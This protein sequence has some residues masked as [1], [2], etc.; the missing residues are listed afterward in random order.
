MGAR[1]HGREG[2]RGFN[3]R[4][5]PAV[6]VC[7]CAPRRGLGCGAHGAHGAHAGV[8]GLYVV[9]V[10]YLAAIDNNRCEQPV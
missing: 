6:C 9:Y 3:I 10:V 8:C 1:A 7:V 5:P 2:T 4:C